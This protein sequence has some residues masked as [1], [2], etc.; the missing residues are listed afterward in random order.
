MLGNTFFSPQDKPN[1]NSAFFELIH[2]SERAGYLQP[3][4]QD[5][6]Q[7]TGA[8]HTQRHGPEER[9]HDYLLSSP[10][11]LGLG[12]GFSHLLRNQLV[13]VTRNDTWISFSQDRQLYTW[14]KA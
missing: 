2:I 7:D 5:N 12:E 11:Q 3:S 6:T 1:R 4:E 8:R 10:A 13:S 14:T 9:G